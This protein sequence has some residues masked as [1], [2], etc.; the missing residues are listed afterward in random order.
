MQRQAAAR[1]RPLAGTRSGGFTLLE[2]MLVL[3]LMGLAVGYVVF[4]AFGS[5]PAE[6]LERHARRL[7]VV[8][9][10]AADYAVMNQQQL[11]I[12]FEPEANEYYFVYLDDDDRWQRLT[13]SKAYAAQTLPEPFFFS[14]N[15]DDLPWDQDQLL[16]DRE[17]FDENFSLDDSQTNIG[18]EQARQLPPPQVL[19]MSSGEI[20]P[21]VLTF[22]YEPRFGGD[23]PA[24]YQLTNQ[25]VPPLALTGPLPQ[26]PQ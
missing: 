25:D 21:F 18:D 7:Q 22:H 5:T 6:E 10:M 24:Y 19:I 23:A 15:L 14:L 3:L 16:L 17:V 11:G 4:N 26:V 8:T 13:G 20:T 12:R 1:W 2:V 9:D